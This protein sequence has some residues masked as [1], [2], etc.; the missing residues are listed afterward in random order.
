MK[1]R[2]LVCAVLLIALGTGA[3]LA[4]APTLDKLNMV[5]LGKTAYEAKALDKN[6]SGAVVIPGTH[7]NLP[8][9]QVSGFNGCTGMTGITI[10]NNVT[11][12]K[13]SAFSG[14]SGLTSVTIPSTVTK[15]EGWGF[16]NCNNLTSV[17]FQGTNI[18]MNASA[19]NTFPGDLVIAFNA[20]GP[21]T[22]TRPARGNNWSRTGGAAVSQQDDRGGRRRDNDRQN[23]NPPPQPAGAETPEKIKFVASGS[24]LRA[25]ALN[26]TISG[27]L[28]IPANHDGKT[29][30]S[31]DRFNDCPGITSV[32]IPSSVTSM[33]GNSFVRCTGITSI[34]IPRNVSSIGYGAF[35]GCNYLTSVTFQ[36]ITNINGAFPGDLAT[37]YK[38]GG[39]GTYTRQAGQNAWTKQ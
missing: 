34:T 26:N 36:G 3:V 18:D 30:T 33:G 29:V 35:S 23:N 6:I 11:V 28:V 32:I 37:K 7:N 27:A 31:I 16:Q 2:V 1:K 25:E 12:I 9:T 14:C 4:Q 19:N 39:E 13:T 38:N 8:V 5:T 20:G 15:I 24:T 21:G 22:Y 10:P 17:T